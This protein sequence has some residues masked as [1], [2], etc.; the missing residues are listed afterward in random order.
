MSVAMATAL[1]GVETS[2]TRFIV[3]DDH[4]LFVEG[5]IGRVRSRYP[6]AVIG[7]AGAS[8]HDALRS[9]VAHG[10]DCAIVDMDLGASMSSAEIVSAFAMHRIPLVV[11]TERPTT[12]GLEAS[13]VAGASAYVSKQARPEDICGAIDAVLD[14]DTWVPGDVVR[15]GTAASTVVLSAQERRVLVLYASGMTQDSV[16]RRLHIAPS[17]VKH[18]LD[19]VR[20]KYTAAGFA[21]RTKLELH[22]L[23]R[24]EGLLP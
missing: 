9:A 6:G 18:Y 13:F 2:R 5:I 15:A 10:C 17:T 14:G 7:Y 3:V 11:L 19:R 1:T 22:A 24:S 12:Q 23:A 21:A 4:P 16:A 8:V 20:E